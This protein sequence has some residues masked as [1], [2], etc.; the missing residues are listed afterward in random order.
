MRAIALEKCAVCAH[1]KSR[2][3][4][5][6]VCREVCREVWLSVLVQW[7]SPVCFNC[8]SGITC[9][10]DIL[11]TCQIA[12]MSAHRMNFKETS[13]YNAFSAL[14]LLDG[15]QE[16]HPACK[17][18]AMRCLYGYL[19]Q[20]RCRFFC[21]WSSWCY[22]IP[23]TH[24]LLSHLPVW[25]RLTWVVLEKRLSNGR[26]SSSSAVKNLAS[27]PSLLVNWPPAASWPVGDLA[28]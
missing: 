13:T 2:A 22:C 17:N 12:D 11:P 9:F 21:V 7:A 16:E 3:V 23:K 1:W 4:Q 20:V 27:C 10:M 18:W 14:T 26:S 6:G 8:H 28:C 25:Y 19:S 5:C 15:R 24:H